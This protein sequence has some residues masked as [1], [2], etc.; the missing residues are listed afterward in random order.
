[1]DGGGG[2]VSADAEVALVD[3]FRQEWPRLVSA[4][5]R[6]LGDLQAAEDVVQETLLGGRHRCD[7]R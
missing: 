1:V 2:G 4:T 7:G 5:V 3:T 6:V